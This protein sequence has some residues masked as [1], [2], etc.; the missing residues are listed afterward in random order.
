MSAPVAIITRT[1]WAVRRQ[2]FWGMKVV[3]SA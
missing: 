3:C 2:G 1:V